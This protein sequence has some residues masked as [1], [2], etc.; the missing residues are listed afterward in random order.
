MFNCLLQVWGWEVHDIREW[1]LPAWLLL[2]QLLLV[3]ALV[4]SLLTRLLSSLVLMR[5]PLVWVLRFNHQMLTVAA[6][7]DIA[8]GL[9]IAVLVVVFSICCWDR[10]AGVNI[11]T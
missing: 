9:V 4:M 7:A 8:A 1:L 2:V 10:S 5:Y 3:L 6:V 11:W